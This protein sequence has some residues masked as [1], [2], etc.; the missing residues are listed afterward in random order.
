MSGGGLTYN[1]YVW[2]YLGYGLMQGRGAVLGTSGS[3]F[4]INAGATGSFT[5]PYGDG[6]SIPL[7]SAPTGGNVQECKKAVVEAMHMQKD[8]GA[9]AN[10]CTFDGAWGAVAS[11]EGRSFYVSSYF[12]DKYDLLSLCTCFLPPFSL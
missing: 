2:S 8:C 6:V 1:V 9:A 3:G 4:C 7:E 11:Q 12:F 10:L 5:S